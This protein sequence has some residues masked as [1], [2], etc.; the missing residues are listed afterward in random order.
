LVP[1]FNLGLLEGKTEKLST[2]VRGS[3]MPK[4]KMKIIFIFIFIFGDQLG[5]DKRKGLMSSL[6]SRNDMVSRC[7][8]QQR[9]KFI[10]NGMWTMFMSS[11]WMP[12]WE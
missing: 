6:Q 4:M 5:L 8:R 1:I 10:V 2:S 12:S 3:K 9:Y 7:D 11:M